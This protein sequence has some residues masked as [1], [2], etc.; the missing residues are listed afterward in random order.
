M[1]ISPMPAATRLRTSGKLG[2]LNPYPY[3]MTLYNSAGWLAYGYGSANP[4]LFP[5]NFLG[6][7]GGIYFTMTAHAVAPRHIQD[8][9]LG[10]VLCAGLHFMTL[11]IVA[12]FALEHSVAEQMWGINAIAIL[13]VYYLI[14]LSTMFQILRTHNAASIYPPLAAA[15]VANGGLWTIYGFA[16]GDVN[17]WL[18]NLFG[19]VLGCVQLLLRVFL[20]SR[21]ESGAPQPLPLHEPPED[22]PAAKHPGAKLPPGVSG[23]RSSILAL[24]HPF[25][26]HSHD[27]VPGSSGPG[28][29]GTGSGP[30][31]GTAGGPGG[32]NP[33]QGAGGAKA[34]T[35]AGGYAAP[36]PFDLEASS[37]TGGAGAG[38]AGPG[39]GPGAAGLGPGGGVAV[40]ATALH[41]KLQ[42]AASNASVTLRQ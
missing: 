29:P 13:M 27:P 9:L 17:L 32:A 2:D 19:A 18:P 4:Y 1:L 8:R 20:G 30:G 38:F 12:T 40:T 42:Q 25:H 10:V 33:S 23:R 15:A 24:L 31:N 39:M 37:G 41:P 14:P 34:G 22:H 26:P 7:L 5:S 21:P 6:F 28:T 3:P 16:I 36:S 11:G 35:G